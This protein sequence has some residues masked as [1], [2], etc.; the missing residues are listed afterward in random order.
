MP[1]RVPLSQNKEFKSFKNA[2]IQEAMNIIVDRTP[3]EDAEKQVA[4]D[5][6]PS[7]T[8]TEPILTDK[9]KTS[10]MWKYYSDAKEHLKKE[11][12][13]YDPNKAVDLLI[14]SARLGCGVAKYRLGKM[15]LRGDEVAKNVDYAL[16]W[17][18]EAVAE[19]NPFAEY[20]LGKTYL[21]GE[22]VERDLLR[23]EELL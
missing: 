18:E 20:L 21:K 14:E 11:C 10:L 17:L 2:V 5:P 9:E 13:S 22:D 8:E 3:I 4:P 15:F 23:A 7:N 16:R 12:E 19:G 1:E 6:E